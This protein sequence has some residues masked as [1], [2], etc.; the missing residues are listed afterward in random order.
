MNHMGE[1]IPIACS[2][3]TD[4]YA[5]RLAAIQEVGGIGLV[6][7]E[8]H[9]GGTGADLFFR[10]GDEIRR[11]LRGVVEAEAKCCAFLD[12]KLDA[13]DGMLRLSISGPADAVPVVQDLVRSLE[14]GREAA[15]GLAAP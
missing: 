13:E 7:T 12:M 8:R 6:R 2:L 4:S 9:D 15:Q 3:D 5:T 1:P 10:D 14:S 11:R